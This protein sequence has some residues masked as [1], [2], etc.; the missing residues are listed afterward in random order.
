MAGEGQR[1]RVFGVR[2]EDRQLHAAHAVLLAGADGDRRA[3]VGEDDRVGGHARFHG[4]REDEVVGFLRGGLAG[5]DGHAVLG[6]GDGGDEV[7]GGTDAVHEGLLE[8][9]AAVGHALDVEEGNARE[10][11]EVGE[12]GQLEDAEVLAGGELFEHAFLEVG[13]GDH[14]EIVGGDEIGGPHVQRTVDHHGPAEG[15]DA[16]APEGLVQGVAHAFLGPRRAAGVV[17]LEDDGGGTFR[18]VLEDVAAVVHVGEVGLARMLSGLQHLRL[19]EGGHDALRAAPFHAVHDQLAGFHFIQGG[20][21][22]GV[23]AVAQP[24]GFAVDVPCALFVCQHGV[25]ERDG[26]GF[27]EGVLQHGAVHIFEAG[28]GVSC[29]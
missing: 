24:L 26:H 21:L 17:V 13:G 11:A 25:A 28:H 19:G 4:P 27:R 9:D 12:G 8:D 7:L 10:F 2:L 14:L 20:G 5:G 18:E 15:G 1:V 16:V 23:F 6:G 3:V 29:L 22:V